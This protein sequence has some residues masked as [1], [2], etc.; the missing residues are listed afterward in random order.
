M[1]KKEFI[2]QG[3]LGG[4]GLSGYA[5]RADLYCRD[6]GG[7]IYHDIA[8]EIAPLLRD[9][10]DPRFSDSDVCPQ[11]IYFG[12]SEYEEH[13]TSCGVYLYGESEDEEITDGMGHDDFDDC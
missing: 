7:D 3:T 13:C 1:T 8:P 12:E 6:C 9:T 11:P 2:Y 5:Y 4:P 10:D